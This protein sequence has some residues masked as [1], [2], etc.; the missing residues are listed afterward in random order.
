MR[1]LPGWLKVPAEDDSGQSCRRGNV[2]V[3]RTCPP[4]AARSGVGRQGR[5]FCTSNSGGSGPPPTQWHGLGPAG[6]G[7]AR[8]IHRFRVGH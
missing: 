1:W 5:L 3:P 2:H 4:P 7:D 6:L 8:A